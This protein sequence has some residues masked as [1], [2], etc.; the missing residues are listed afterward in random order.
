MSELLEVNCALQSGQMAEDYLANRISYFVSAD[1][2][3]CV[4]EIAADGI[5]V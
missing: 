4:P 3:D 5:F 2:K 1:V